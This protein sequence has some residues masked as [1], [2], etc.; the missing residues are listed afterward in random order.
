MSTVA[1][2]TQCGATLPTD[3]LGKRCPCCLVQ[4]ALDI[5]VDQ[6]A[7]GEGLASTESTLGRGHSF[8]DYEVLEVIARG[9]MGIVYKARQKSLNRIVAV[10]LMLSS[11][12]RLHPMAPAVATHTSVI[13]P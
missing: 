6:A 2:C 1:H 10:K 5:S 7:P 3:I 13:V 12:P 8:G 9:G 11:E 4:L